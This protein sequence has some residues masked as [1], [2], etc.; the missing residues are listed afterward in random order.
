MSYT[1]YIASISLV[2]LASFGVARTIAQNAPRDELFQQAPTPSI[3]QPVKS[4]ALSAVDSTPSPTTEKVTIAQLQE[5]AL[6][7]H[8]LYKI[9]ESAI[10]AERGSRTQASLRPNPTLR[11]Q[12]EEIG[13]D[14][15]A[16]KQGFTLEQEF[17][18]YE[19]RRLLVQ[20][21]DRSIEALT[22]NKEIAS[23]KIRNDVYSLAFRLLIA[24]KKVD[25]L[26]QLVSI[27]Q[28]SEDAARVAIQA[29]S[30]E[31]TQLQFIQIQNQTRQAKL[32]LTQE[33]NV[34][35]S[36]EK[37][38]AVV[39]GEP[40][41]P[42][43]EID[44]N[45][46]TLVELDAFDEAA[47]LNEI[48]ENSPEIAQKKAEIRQKQ[49]VVA[50]ERSPQRE[51][52]IEGGTT[53][54]FSDNTTLAQIGVGVPIRINNR[55]EGNIQR[56]VAEYFTAQKELE[57]LQLRLRA[58]FTEVFS[59][60]KTARDE[61]VAYQREILPDLEKLFSMSQLAYQQGQI[62]FLEISAARTSYI[63]S[64]LNYLEALNRLADSIAK[65]KGTL[66]ENSLED[67]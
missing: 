67:E 49:A 58:K 18:S 2:F 38:L 65:I 34:Q 13:S 26:R 3:A 9:A 29:G 42:I 17:G 4:R 7:N 53:Y 32:M 10:E 28:T 35:E 12:G 21:S 64:F 22:W 59:E 51:F 54:D 37:K 43:G 66:L 61:V 31:I 16:G 50:F 57:K 44:D 36:L 45:P 63:E 5:K 8:P 30:I 48:L 27:S 11:Y 14:G 39:V 55:N 33:T 20:A 47:T 60:Y 1:R 56:A 23:A 24:R 52:S 6:R 15:K 46:E 62:N 41:E 40:N 19:R 25:F